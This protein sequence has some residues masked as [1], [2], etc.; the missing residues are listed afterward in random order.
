MQFKTRIFMFTSKLLSRQKIQIPLNWRTVS[1]ILD[2]LYSCSFIRPESKAHGCSYSFGSVQ[3]PLS[4][5][6]HLVMLRMLDWV[7]RWNSNLQAK[8]S[9]EPVCCPQHH[10]SWA[11]SPTTSLQIFSY[12]TN[13]RSMSLKPQLPEMEP[14]HFYLNLLIELYI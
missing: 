3:F 8:R 1:H 11:F 2:K 10:S 5:P 7:R 13:L 4:F 6:R 12:S 9:E 14:I